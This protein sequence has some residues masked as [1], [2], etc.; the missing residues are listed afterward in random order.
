TGKY[1]NWI[2]TSILPVL[3]D[4]RGNPIG[5]GDLVKADLTFDLHAAYEFEGDLLNGSQI[6]IDVKNVFDKTPPFYNGNTTGVGVG[7]WGF[8]GF[9]SNVLG[10]LMSVGFRAAF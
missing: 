10:R 7:A 1:H 4:A 2:N 5:G 8:N 6:Y 3:S 9:T